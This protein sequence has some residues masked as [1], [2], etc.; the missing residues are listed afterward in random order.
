LVRKSNIMHVHISIERFDWSYSTITW[1][2]LVKVGHITMQNFVNPTK[3]VSRLKRRH[4]AMPWRGRGD[5]TLTVDRRPTTTGLQDD[6]LPMSVYNAK[7]GTALMTRTSHAKTKKSLVA[8]V[9]RSCATTAA[10]SIDLTASVMIRLCQSLNRLKFRLCASAVCTRN[11]Y[12]S[13]RHNCVRLYSEASMYKRK[14]NARTE[15]Y[16]VYMSMMTRTLFL[17]TSRS[18]RVSVRPTRAN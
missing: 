14:R 15:M 7:T 11:G 16:D 3:S 13:L 6:W 5:A 9:V 12:S 2:G 1:R 17:D 18:E 10:A 4:S 8:T